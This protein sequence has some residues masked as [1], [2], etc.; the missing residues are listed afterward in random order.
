MADHSLG[1]WNILPVIKLNKNIQCS[2]LL[3]TR[4]TTLR[5]KEDRTLGG[6]VEGLLVFFPWKDQIYCLTWQFWCS[7]DT[8]QMFKADV[9]CFQSWGVCRIWSNTS[10]RTRLP[11]NWITHS[12]EHLCLIILCSSELSLF[13][14]MKWNILDKIIP[15]NKGTLQ[16][17]DHFYCIDNNIDTVREYCLACKIVWWVD[18]TF[19]FWYTEISGLVLLKEKCTFH[20]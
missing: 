1:H 16:R 14:Q 15:P 8:A 17:W 7:K 11:T 12:H 2:G 9:I 5:T 3:F 19:Q 10:Q 18:Q 6:W 13:S 20:L 4:A